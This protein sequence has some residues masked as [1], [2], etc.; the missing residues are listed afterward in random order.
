MIAKILNLPALK[1]QLEG[2]LQQRLNKG[3]PLS[4][5]LL[6]HGEANLSYRL[7]QTSLV[8]VAVN[9]QLRLQAEALLDQ[10]PY[11]CL[12]HS[13]HTYDNWVIN[14]KACEDMTES[15]IAE[16]SVAVAEAIALF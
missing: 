13:D 12:V 7:N 6:A 2:H 16:A 8:R 9:A 1:A 14:D 10:Y 4:L 5:E 15:R 11:V 3:E